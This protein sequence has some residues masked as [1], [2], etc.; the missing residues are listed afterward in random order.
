MRQIVHDGK[1][2]RLADNGKVERLAFRHDRVLGQILSDGVV[3]LINTGKLD[4]AVC[5]EPFLADVIGVAVAAA[6]TASEIIGRAGKSNPLALF[7]ALKSFREPSAEAHRAVLKT[8]FAWLSADDTHTRARRTMRWAALQVLSETDSS[9]V[10]PI[11]DQFKD[12]TWAKQ[13]A[14]FRS[15][16]VVAGIRLC[17]RLKPGVTSSWR[18]QHIDHAKARFG[19]ALLEGL[20]E[21]LRQPDLASDMRIGALRLAGHLGESS[22]ADAIIASWIS[23]RH[24]TDRL[25]DYLWAAAECCDTSPERLLGPVCDAWA[26]LSDEPSKEG[27]PSPRSYLAHDHLSWAFREVGIPSPALGYFIYRA[28]REDLRWPIILMLRGVDHPD[29]VEFLVCEFA[30]SCR[31]F[32]GTKG[33]WPFPDHVR[34][35]WERQQREKCKGMSLVSRERLRVIW[36]NISNDKHLRRQAFL[37]WAAT[38]AK[39]D[40]ACLQNVEASGPLADDILWTRLKRGDQTAVAPLLTKIQADERGYWWQAGRLIWSDDLTVALDETFQRRGN[41]VRRE[42][43][44]SYPTDWITYQ[45][46]M[47]LKPGTAEQLLVK[48]W[49]HLQY[50]SYFVQTALYLATPTLV[51]LAADAILRSPD[52]RVMLK[53]VDQHFGIKVQGHP[54]VTRIEQVKALVPYLDYLDSMEIHDLWEICNERGWMEFRCAYLDPR[55]DGQWREREMVN[56]H[57]ADYFKYF[58]AQLETEHGHS[59][60]YWLDRYLRQNGRIEDILNALRKWLIAR[61]T[62]CALEFAAAVVIH[63]GRR[64]DI[65]LLSVD[66]IEPAEEANAIVDDARFAVRRR[67][68]V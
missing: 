18:D 48:H 61:R 4:D 29:A 60:H 11:A 39:G 63:A 67:S 55:L 65:D 25:R 44:A 14:R 59:V 49:E 30:A 19:R 64:C 27:V 28:Q 68:L 45:L 41:T 58:D 51:T 22:L 31:K 54:G 24:R 16:D 12:E 34:G 5:G 33:F 6:N 53:H 43:D 42:W 50:S 46:L 66:G 56:L 10:L 37:H 62:I 1:V 40:V 13:L 17:R 35:D 52:A 20:D 57:E 3:E 26:G 9:Y 32:E 21:L 38:S 36:E 2:V 7:Y 47:R 23:D 8:I 15:G